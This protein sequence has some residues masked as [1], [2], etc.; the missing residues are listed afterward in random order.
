MSHEANIQTLPQSFRNATEGAQGCPR[1]TRFDATNDALVNARSLRELVL[2]KMSGKTR[3]YDSLSGK[4]F[5]LT[6]LPFRA[7]SWILQL[8]F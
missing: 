4:K 7:K 1:G 6:R 2:G 8:L 5:G 3:L